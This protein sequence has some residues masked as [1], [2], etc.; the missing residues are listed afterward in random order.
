[1]KSNSELRKQIQNR[2]KSDDDLDA[3]CI[4]YFPNIK[5]QFT[6]GM[7]RTAKE[8]KLIELA[9]LEALET[10]LWQNEES[11]NNST[12]LSRIENLFQQ[13]NYVFSKFNDLISYDLAVNA[14][15]ELLPSL[16]DQNRSIKIEGSIEK[17]RLLSS[18]FEQAFSTCR[19][20]YIESTFWL[21]DQDRKAIEEYL[22][23]F[24]SLAEPIN[25]N[26][27]LML[28]LANFDQAKFILL[29]NTNK[30]MQDCK[31]WL[32]SIASARKSI[33]N[34]LRRYKK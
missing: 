9:D 24:S 22:G 34:E 32:Q 11:V 8:T 3:F 25:K 30:Q 4:D 20:T 6:N 33:E 7:T 16:A 31:F 26:L 2:F 12:S 1:M 23:K 19:K 17:L 13:I 21:N 18:S 15:G 5:R 14:A 10:L 27:I 28:S 29:L